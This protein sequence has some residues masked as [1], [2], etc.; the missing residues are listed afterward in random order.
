MATLAPERR[1]VTFQD[2]GAGFLRRGAAR[3]G[4]SVPGV[5]TSTV[6]MAMIKHVKRRFS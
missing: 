3:E 4:T 2:A 5:F 6:T 1:N